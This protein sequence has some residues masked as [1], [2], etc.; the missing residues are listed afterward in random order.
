MSST[1]VTLASTGS[2]YSAFDTYLGGIISVVT[3]VTGMGVEFST[4]LPQDFA[5]TGWPGF[6]LAL[7]DAGNRPSFLSS[8]WCD[9]N[10]RSDLFQPAALRSAKISLVVSPSA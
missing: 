10:V 8:V 3:G 6:S 1:T 7:L 4:G 2:L 5:A 9:C